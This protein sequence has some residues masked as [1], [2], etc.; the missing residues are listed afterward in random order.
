ME[1][2]IFEI[3]QTEHHDCGGE[4]PCYLCGKEVKRPRYMI[5][6]VN[7]GGDA[8]AKG[9]APDEN[10]PGYMGFHYIGPECRKKLPANF[11]HDLTK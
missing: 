7:G 2:A 4:M 5:E 10:D 8:A 9:L 11:V 6:V 1:T 3:P